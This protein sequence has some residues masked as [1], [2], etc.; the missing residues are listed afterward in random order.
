MSSSTAL[1]PRVHAQI[2]STVSLVLGLPATRVQTLSVREMFV[3][4]QQHGFEVDIMVEKPADLND[5]EVG[6]SA[7]LDIAA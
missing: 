1:S 6:F 2:A 4:C 7:E 3:L 5:D